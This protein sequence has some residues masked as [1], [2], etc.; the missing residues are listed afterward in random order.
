V[1]T[2]PRKPTIS[3]KKRYITTWRQV[4]IKSVRALTWTEPLQFKEAQVLWYHRV[5]VARTMVASFASLPIAIGCFY[6]RPFW[7]SCAWRNHGATKI[8]TRNY[9]NIIIYTTIDRGKKKQGLPKNPKSYFIVYLGKLN[10]RS[11]IYHTSL[12]FSELGC[13]YSD[14]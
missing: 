10:S 6:I 4:G 13:V 14:S 1:T 2:G 3:D 7:F 8:W 11:F 12:Y 9:G 5:S